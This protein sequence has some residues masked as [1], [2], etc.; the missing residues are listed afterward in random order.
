M[1]TQRQALAWLLTP[2]LAFSTTLAGVLVLFYG[3]SELV[4]ALAGGV[5]ALC[6]TPDCV[7]GLGLML[8]AGGF[9]VLCA[10]VVAGTVVGLVHREQSEARA[11]VR[12]GLFVALWCV[13]AYLVGSVVVSVV[14]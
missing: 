7:L 3:Q 12:R 4:P 1:P 13:L 8:I 11:A 9:L 10:S 2:L 14:V 5:G 6:R